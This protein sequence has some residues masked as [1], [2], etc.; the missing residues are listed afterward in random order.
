MLTRRQFAIGS[1]AITSASIIGRRI[2]EARATHFNIP[3]PI[4]RLV[5]AAKQENAVSLKVAAGR[6][7]FVRG[8][9]AKTHG[10]SALIL[11]PVIRM[12]RGDNIEMTMASSWCLVIVTEGSAQAVSFRCTLTQFAALLSSCNGLRSIIDYGLEPSADRS[13]RR[14]SLGTVSAASIETAL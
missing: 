13:G 7:A 11:G 3:L 12:C 2:A 8:K 14:L 1:A 6:H 4:P 10:Y 9:P 5:D